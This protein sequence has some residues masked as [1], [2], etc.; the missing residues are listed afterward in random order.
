MSSIFFLYALYWPLSRAVLLIMRLVWRADERAQK[1]QLSERQAAKE[2][3]L[4]LLHWLFT[5]LN[6]RTQ[7]FKF[8]SEIGRNSNVPLPSPAHLF[9]KAV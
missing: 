5:L 4:V 9:Q 7:L 6:V 3:Q 1:R 8:V 2:P